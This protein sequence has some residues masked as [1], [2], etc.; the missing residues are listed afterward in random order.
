MTQTKLG[1]RFDQ[2]LSLDETELNQIA[3]AVSERRAQCTARKKLVLSVG[4][5]VTFMGRS[6]GVWAG[7]QT[8]TLVKKNRKKGVVQVL[9]PHTKRPIKWTVPFT[10]LTPAEGF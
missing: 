2:V 5:T 3:E 6:R 10:M 9:H 8:G 4:D 1:K 7:W